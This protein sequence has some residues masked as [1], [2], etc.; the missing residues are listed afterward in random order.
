MSVFRSGGI[1]ITAISAAVPKCKKT[2]EDYVDKF[3]ATAVERFEKVTGIKEVHQAS[4]NQTASDLGYE[5]AERVIHEMRIDRNEIGLLVFVTNSP[6][7]RFP[8]SACILQHRLKL[9][10]ECA[11][12]DMGLGCS[13]FI[14]G[15]QA[16]AGM[17]PDDRQYAL[18]IIGDTIS[19]LNIQDDKSVAMMFGDAGAA[20]L[21][22]KNNDI[23][24][25]SLL[26]TDGSRFRNITS[27]GGGFRDMDPEHE[28]AFFMDGMGVF[29][30]STSDVPSAIGD[31]LK[32]TNLDINFFDI[33]LMHQ[34]NQLIVDRISHKLGI[35]KE[36]IPV[37]L[38]RYGN[39]GG[40]SI[41]LT[42]CDF[43]GGKKSGVQNVLM[44]G[45]GVG[46]SW[47]VTSLAVNTECIL[48]VIC[49]DSYYQDNGV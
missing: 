48:P 3:G 46:L 34:A 5:A 35:P 22:R 2:R 41:P 20:V 19:R 37:T 18:L 49:T 42:L 39:T 9:S 47:G 12:F 6:D 15:L 40:A 26:R 24:N 30:F 28:Y 11:A 43:Y 44:A 25:T 45:F 38:D 10:V 4:H 23:Q 31:Y 8:A 16:V 29:A 32:A 21:L 14:Y 17:M 1:E 33:V 7:Y 13:G 27:I 36:K